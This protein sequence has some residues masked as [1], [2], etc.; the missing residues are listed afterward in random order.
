MPGAIALFTR[1]PLDEILEN[2]GTGDWVTSADRVRQYPFVVLV[3]NRNHPSSPSDVDHGTAFLIGRVF[4]T[5][6][7]EKR[8]AN[9]YPRIFIELKDYA[10]VNVKNVWSKSQ[11][12]VW[13]TN[14]E[15]LGIDENEIEFAPISHVAT[16]QRETAASENNALAEIK[17]DLAKLFNVPASAVEIT[18]R[19]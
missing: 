1:E 13:Y 8:A 3:R 5:R 17:R 15:T 7:A 9:G 10:Q 6:V 18:I 11:N 19:L 12:P 2:G 16:A 4:G 14:L